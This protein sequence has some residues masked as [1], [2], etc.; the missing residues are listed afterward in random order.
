MN[1]KIFIY[2]IVGILIFVGLSLSFLSLNNNF[3]KN[4]NKLE[5][6]VISANDHVVM[7][8]DKDNIIY[9]FNTKK[10]KECH[11]N[12]MVLEY[13]GIIDKNMEFQDISIIN[14]KPIS[15][16]NNNGIPILFNDN[17]MFS[18]YY[19]LAYKKVMNMSLDEKIAQILLVRYPSNGVDILKE[20]QFGGYV[21]FSKDFTNKNKDEVKKMMNDL[22]LVANIPILTAVDEE[23][24]VVVR[25][26]NNPSLSNEKFL[27]PSSLYE[28]GGFTLIRQDTI[29]KGKLLK[30]LGINLNLAP[31]VDVV[32]DSNSYMYNR[33][34]QENSELT[35]EYAKTVITASQGT[36]V[37]YTL[38]HF[39]GYGNNTD[40]HAG[41]ATDNRTYEE[42][43]I[44]D[45]PPFKAGIK[46]GAEAILV[47]HNIVSEIDSNNPSSLSPS[48]H[49]LLRNEL[50]FTGIII[51]DDLSMGATNSINSSAVKAVLAGNDL[52]ISTNYVKDI[53]DIKN[54]IDNKVLSED[55]IDKLAMRV[56][57]WKYY[58]GLLEN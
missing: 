34:L 20:Y 27:S 8:Q 42:I 32:T 6:T 46:S 30:N 41:S 58:K 49:N 19:E 38:K 36:G 23:G 55:I 40:T 48:I 51:T 35:S 50:E 15:A 37:S 9:T 12:N 33:A 10:F 56:I 16:S 2:I 21:F 31:V 54:A 13:T 52:I 24:G 25:V 3:E 47:S 18:N 7:V 4:V 5:V 39:P 44:N 22:Q 57:A 17:G 29:N 43:L 53:E 28:Q 26:S 45:L 1:N 14:C 11:G